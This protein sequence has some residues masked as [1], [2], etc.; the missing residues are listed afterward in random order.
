VRGPA[1]MTLDP[2][3][4]V[5][6]WTPQANHIPST[7]QITIKVTD[8]GDPPLG[9]TK[10]FDVIVQRKAASAPPRITSPRLWADGRFSFEFTAEPG[11]AYTIE[12]S[13]DLTNWESVVVLPADGQ[14]HGEFSESLPA[15][16]YNRYYRMVEQ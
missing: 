11:R 12:A 5:L 7:N 8:D 2:I 3:S 13:P 10:S 6:N 1:G 16:L 14:G 9:D 15:K 4:G